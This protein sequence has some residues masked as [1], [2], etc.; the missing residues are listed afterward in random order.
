MAASRTAELA[1]FCS[2]LSYDDLPDAVAA[3]AKTI[4]LDSLGCGL[5]GCRTELGRAVLRAHGQLATAAGAA[6]IID[7]REPTAPEVA[8][9]ANAFYINALD[10]DETSRFG[11]PSSTVVSTALAWAE[12]YRRGGAELLTAI[13]A[14]YEVSE[15]VAASIWPSRGREAQAWGVGTHQTLGAGAAGCSLA[16]LSPADS[17]ATLGLAAVMAALPSAWQW[18]WGDRP[19][20]WHKDS[21]AWAAFSG[22]QALRLR[23]AGFEGPRNALEGDKSLW[24]LIGSDR[25]DPDRLTSGLGSEW[26]ILESG[27]KLYSCCRWLHSILDAALEAIGGRELRAADISSVEVNGVAMIEDYDFIDPAPR[28]MVDA[29][30]SVNYT[31][32]VALLGVPPGPGWFAPEQIADPDVTGLASRVRFTADDEATRVY[33]EDRAAM[34]ARVTVALASGE[35]LEGTARYPSGGPECPA[36]RDAV[37]SKYRRL[38][39]SVLDAEAAEALMQ[40][41]WRTEELRD[42]AILLRPSA[43]SR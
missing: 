9:L 1:E 28:N 16:G 33:R 17:A 30:F 35:R 18:N 12:E 41:V 3:R 40:E 23:V 15:R 42:V 31:V 38:A 39:A 26:L 13:V 11:H 43:L 4:L 27:I 2:S 36:T 20:S 29:E 32:A 25:C 21:V 10:Y 22:A 5:A 14:G 7:R 8:A 34:P 19:L 37:E 24:R 6:H